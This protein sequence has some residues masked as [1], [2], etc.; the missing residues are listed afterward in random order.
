MTGRLQPRSRLKQARH[1]ELAAH[2]GTAIG[3]NREL[4]RADG[5]LEARRLDQ[6]L[7]QA[8]VL[9]GRDHP[10]QHELSDA[11]RLKELETENGRLKKRSRARSYEKKW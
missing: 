6:A 11:K 1:H 5:V 7:R 8:G 10:A 3:V 9:L 4:V 2:G